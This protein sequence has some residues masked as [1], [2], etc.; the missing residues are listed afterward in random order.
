MSSS[1]TPW[2]RT[3]RA[4][5][6]LLVLFPP[7]GLY[8][9]WRFQD[10]NSRRKQITTGASVLWTAGIICGITLAI[11]LGGGGEEGEEPVAAGPQEAA[12]RGF[13]DPVR[14]YEVQW[15]D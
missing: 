15:Q 10:W 1:T 7:A 6:V 5:I 4:A 14:L 12:L 13:E 9:M 2:Y 8:L 3:E 11:V